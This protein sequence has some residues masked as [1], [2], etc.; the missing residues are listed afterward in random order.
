MGNLTLQLKE[1]YKMVV[2]PGYFKE[3]DRKQEAAKMW[4][5]R[6]SLYIR[7]LHYRQRGDIRKKIN[8]PIFKK[9]L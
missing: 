1:L 5:L 7:T 3:K 6:P 2:T 9:N 8:I 4:F